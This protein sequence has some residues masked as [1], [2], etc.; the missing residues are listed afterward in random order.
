MKII[1]KFNKEESELVH[2]A[3]SLNFVQV[4]NK[5][6]EIGRNVILKFEKNNNG[7]ISPYILLDDKT[8]EV[9]VEYEFKRTFRISHNLVYSFQCDQAEELVKNNH[10]LDIFIINGDIYGFYEELKGLSIHPFKFYP[11]E[12]SLIVLTE[13]QKE[14]SSYHFSKKPIENFNAVLDKALAELVQENF[15][16]LCMSKYGKQAE[17][18]M[19]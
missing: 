7:T 18:L 19:I 14:K 12:N 15:Q 1:K 4:Q 16:R 11:E 5:L 3:C 13:F 17:L 8:A 10:G 9:K 6:R 2:K